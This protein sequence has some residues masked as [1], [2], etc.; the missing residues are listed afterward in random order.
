M[1]ILLLSLEYINVGSYIPFLD[2]I[3]PGTLILSKTLLL[4]TVNE[5]QS[6]KSRY[7]ISLGHFRK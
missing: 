2:S 1:I 7:I 5:V 4:M 6:S 3:M